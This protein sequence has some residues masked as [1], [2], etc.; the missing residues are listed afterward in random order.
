M[1]ARGYVNSIRTHLVRLTKTID[2]THFALL[3]RI[4]Q[5]AHSWS[6]SRDTQHKV[7]SVF[8]RNILPQLSKK[9]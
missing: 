5:D 2:S 9:P 7:L 4:A 8:L 6:L 1:R 3:I